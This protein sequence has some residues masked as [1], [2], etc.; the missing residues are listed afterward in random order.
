MNRS[1]N[2]QTDIILL[3]L[4]RLETLLATN[5]ILYSCRFLLH[6]GLKQRRNYTKFQKN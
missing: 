1:A 6:L 2:R 3:Y 5:A 4:S